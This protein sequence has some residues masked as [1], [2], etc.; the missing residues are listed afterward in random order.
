MRNKL[1]ET[2]IYITDAGDYQLEASG[3][4]TER[5]VKMLCELQ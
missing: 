3:L 4:R 5:D 2:Y 1:S